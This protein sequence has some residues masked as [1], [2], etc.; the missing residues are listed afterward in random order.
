MTESHQLTHNSFQFVTL[1][2]LSTLTIHDTAV[3]NHIYHKKC[4]ADD[5]IHIKYPALSNYPSTYMD[6]H[7]CVLL[8]PVV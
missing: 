7:T 4:K 3:K 1:T 5:M 6:M 2:L 8:H